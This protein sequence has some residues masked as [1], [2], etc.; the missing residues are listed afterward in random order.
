M[1]LGAFLFTGCLSRKPLTKE[2]FAFTVPQPAQVGAAANAPVLT[3]REVSV[4]A[5][6]D[7]TSLTYRTGEYSY[8]RDPY[9]GFLVSPAESVKGPIRALLQNTGRFSAVIGVASSLRGTLNLEIAVTQMYGDC[10][11]NKSQPVA[12]LEMHS[13][14]FH[15]T[16]RFGRAAK[17]GPELVFQKTYVHRVPLKARSANAVVEGL[18]EALNHIVSRFASDVSNS[19]APRD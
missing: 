17:P 16:Q 19:P 5:P 2:S 18:N 1:A 3:L 7:S 8:E 15:P 10:F 6:F 9:A 13:V 4:A 11:R 12:V 14:L